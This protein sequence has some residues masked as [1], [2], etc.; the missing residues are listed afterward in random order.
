MASTK[1]P[2]RRPDDD[3]ASPARIRDAAVDRFGRDGFDVGLRAIATD[4]GVTAGLVVHHFG[5]KDGLRRA[6]D[7]HVLSVVRAEKTKALTDRSAV[8]LMAQLAQVEQFAPM[9]RYLLRSLQAGGELAGALVDQMTA[10]ADAYL[11]AGVAAGVVRPSR[12]PEARSRHL[13]YQAVG[14]M[15]LWFSL[16]AP[17]VDNADFG[18][19][20]RQYVDQV[21]APALELF[22][23]GLLVDRSMLDGY[24]LYVPDPP[25]KG[26]A[27]EAAR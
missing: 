21:T 24:L 20:F 22:A 12:D 2:S 19:R 26:A 10:D 27:P 5:S 15:V 1:G 13:T 18:T 11:A 16:H 23:Q 25:P 14:G 6:C 8:T 17:A 9:V 4:A 7:Q 3:T